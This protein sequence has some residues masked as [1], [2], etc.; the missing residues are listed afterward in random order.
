MKERI[1]IDQ[2]HVIA[3][4]ITPWVD[5]Y[6]NTYNDNLKVSDITMWDWH[7]LTKPECGEKVYKLLTPDLFESLPVVVGSQEVVEKL[8]ERYEVFIVTAASKS[9]IIPSKA[10]WLK[11]H[12]PFIKKENI[13]YTVN[14]SICLAN[15]LLDDAP[16]NLETFRGEKL[17]YNASHNQS[18]E[19]DS[20]FYRMRN[21]ND[22]ATYFGV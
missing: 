11:E 14:K 8:T 18:E 15:Y 21:W 22:V 1:C 13:V 12:F 19:Y 7:I 10:K 17:L 2:D 16:H 20:R 6:N 5:K 9:S 3:D 4:L